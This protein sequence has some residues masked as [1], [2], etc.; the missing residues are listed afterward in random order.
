MR[1]LAEYLD[2]RGA[3]PFGK[4]FDRLNREAAAEVTRAL[5][6][7]ELGYRSKLKSVGA[8]VFEYKID[9]GPGYRVYFGRDGDHIVILLGGGTKRH[10]SMDIQQAKER[11]KNY[12][13]RK[14]SK[15]SA[16]H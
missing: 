15:G 12:K 5:V 2:D 14:R 9:F 1:T 7:L 10:Q 8:G 16:W 13:R 3:R 4:W 6:R 11:W